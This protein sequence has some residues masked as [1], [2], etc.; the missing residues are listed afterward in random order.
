MSAIYLNLPGL[1]LRVSDDVPTLKLRDDFTEDLVTREL[2]LDDLRALGEACLKAAGDL[3][4]SRRR[5]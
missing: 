3:Q 2:S 5:P 1:E 4:D